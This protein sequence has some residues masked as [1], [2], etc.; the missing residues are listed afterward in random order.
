M[1]RPILHYP[2]RSLR[3]RCEPVH[4]VTRE[5]ISLVNDLA[6]TMYAAPGV[7]LAAPQV[8]VPLRVFVVDVTPSDKEAFLRVFINPEIV[9][10]TGS[11]DSL[12]GCLSLPGVNKV[13]ERSA[14]I[15]VR[16]IGLDGDPV[17]LVADGLLSFAI[18]HELDHLDG[19]LLTQGR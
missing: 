9:H 4:E 19:I 8:G 18:Q 16:S 5:I 7:G 2:N 3:Q 17:E 1:I 10:R 6:E 13:I 11:A 14:G 12:E 15:I